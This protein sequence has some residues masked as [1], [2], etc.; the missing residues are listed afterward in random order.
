MGT[1]VGARLS[2]GTDA[3]ISSAPV[4]WDGGS[5]RSV[6]VSSAA[7]LFNSSGSGLSRIFL[8]RS[9]ELLGLLHI[10]QLHLLLQ[11]GELQNRNLGCWEE[12]TR[13]KIEW[14]WIE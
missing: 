11:D 14:N 5:R 10:Y 6:P 7:G 1:A 8:P 4:P 12:K 9:P 2:P 3:N 13:C